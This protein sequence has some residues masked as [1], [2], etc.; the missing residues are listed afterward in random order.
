MKNVTILLQG[1]I[2]QETIDFFV[3]HYPTQNVVVST[4]IGSKL[5]LSKLPQSYNVILTKLPKNGGHQNI[6]YQ[7]LSTNNGLKCVETDYVI[8]LRGDEY[9]SNLEYIAYEIAMNPHKIHCSSVFF[10]HWEFMQYHISDHIIAGTISNVKLM[11]EKTK[12]YME[13][14]LVYNLRDGIKHE[15]WE[16][17]INLTRSYLMTKE[18]ER[19]GN[20]DGRYLMIE[21]FE[22]LDIK[23]L[24]PYKVVANIFNTQWTEGFIP[25]RNYSISNINKLLLKQDEAYA[26][27][28][29]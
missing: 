12:F 19:W 1:K 11:F 28:I 14:N 2:L 4:W 3:K 17:E 9:Y 20:M 13:N 18:P 10:R 22:I 23:K 5:D 15:F 7:L 6:A 27:N 21:N 8:K 26:L 25:E 16:P 24:E 29:T